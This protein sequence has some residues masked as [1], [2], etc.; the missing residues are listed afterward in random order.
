MKAI[1][2]TNKQIMTIF[3][4]ES[5]MFG[6]IGGIIGV[7]L[8]S[9]GAFLVKLVASIVGFE[10]IKISLNLGLILFS[11]GFAVGIGMLSGFIP[12]YQAAKLKPVEALRYE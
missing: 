10:L 11:L 2:A 9:L 5:A 7:S 3:L 8:G 6:L 1:G 4:V 12:A